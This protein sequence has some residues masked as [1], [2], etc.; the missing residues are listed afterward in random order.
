VDI[1]GQHVRGATHVLVRKNRVAIG[2][3]GNQMTL[4]DFFTKGVLVSKV[5]YPPSYIPKIVD[6]PH[7]DLDSYCQQRI[8]H[9]F[10]N[11]FISIRND[12]INVHPLLNDHKI[13]KV[14]YVEPN[15]R[16]T[17]LGLTNEVIQIERTF[18][19]FE[20]LTMYYNK[21]SLIPSFLNFWKWASW[22]NNMTM[23]KCEQSSRWDLLQKNEFA[24]SCRKVESRCHVAND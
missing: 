9:G 17:I 3:I 16:H 24:K 10:H 23:P 15:Y 11:Y 19:H 1:I 22:L 21:C 6:I 12:L 8:C 7:N 5:E 14:W 18:R 20:Y 4:Q 13:G 2:T